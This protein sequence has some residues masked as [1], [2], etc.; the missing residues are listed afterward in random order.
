MKKEERK[1]LIDLLDFYREYWNNETT[2]S[3]EIVDYFIEN[4]LK[5]SK[6]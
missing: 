2:K 4:E 6:N 1:T 5:D 3:S